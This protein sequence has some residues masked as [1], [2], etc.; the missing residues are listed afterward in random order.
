[1]LLLVFSTKTTSL[2]EYRSQFVL[3]KTTKNCYK[4]RRSF[5]SQHIVNIVIPVP[6]NSAKMHAKIFA[7]FL[8]LSSVHLSMGK[9]GAGLI[10][11]RRKGKNVEYLL[12]KSKKKDASWGPPKG[13]IWRIFWRI[14]RTIWKWNTKFAKSITQKLLIIVLNFARWSW[15]KRCN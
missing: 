7:I 10:I 11:F 14:F 1:M 13:N 5:S 12:L 15:G 8:I 9:K 3:T 2:N 4:L 6:S